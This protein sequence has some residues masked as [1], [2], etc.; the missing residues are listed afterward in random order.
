MGREEKVTLEERYTTK[1][2]EFKKRAL[3]RFKMQKL[4]EIA[5]FSVLVMLL[6]TP[7]S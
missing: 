2:P 7:R 5:T 4:E 3:N 1:N 6:G